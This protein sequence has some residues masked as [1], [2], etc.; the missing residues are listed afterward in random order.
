MEAVVGWL[1]DQSP[2]VTVLPRAMVA[3]AQTAEG[4]LMAPG[5]A[6]TETVV[7]MK[8]EEGSV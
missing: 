3:P 6:P 4:P 5:P 8:Q 7:V 2:P 1:L